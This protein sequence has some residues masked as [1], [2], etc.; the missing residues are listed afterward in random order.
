MAL[1]DFMFDLIFMFLIPSSVS[2]LP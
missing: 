1:P 2:C